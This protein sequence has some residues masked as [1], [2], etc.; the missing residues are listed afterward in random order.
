MSIQVIQNLL[1]AGFS[2]LGIFYYMERPESFQLL[3]L[4]L[5]YSVQRFET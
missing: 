3:I 5:Q 1:E 2:S 4:P